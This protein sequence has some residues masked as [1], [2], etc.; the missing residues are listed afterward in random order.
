MRA[1]MRI[2]IKTN[3]ALSL[4]LASVLLTLVAVSAHSASAQTVPEAGGAH[5]AELAVGYSYVRSNAPP[6][7]CGCFNLNGGSATFAWPIR[8]GNLAI[9]GDVVSAY[10]NLT[11][12]SGYS[13]I[14]SAYTA[15]VRY[16]PSM[17]HSSLRPFGQVLVGVA[18]ASGTAVQAPNPGAANAGASF[19]ANVG[20]GYDMRLSE[21]L[22]IRL[23]EADY[24]VTTL[25]N[26]SNNHQNNLRINAG[27]VFR[28]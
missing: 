12:A 21:H 27:V 20:G 25:D 24:L 19:A 11:S 28:F 3:F 15:G 7:G 4:L 26:G 22:L 18:H 2:T 8:Q 6:G 1:P 10:T 23:V 16:T 14:L 17:G 13:L 9:V 5:H